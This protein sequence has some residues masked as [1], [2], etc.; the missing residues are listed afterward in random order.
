MFSQDSLNIWNLSKGIALFLESTFISIDENQ[1][2]EG[3]WQLD[4]Q[5]VE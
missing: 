1:F 3:L 5:N 4:I 2:K